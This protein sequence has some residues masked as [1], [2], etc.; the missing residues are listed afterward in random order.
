MK[1]HESLNALRM[2]S[3]GCTIVSVILHHQDLAI[4]A[5][6]RNG[7]A[8]SG[9]DVEFTAAMVETVFKYHTC[10][11]CQIAKWNHPAV[12][13]GSGVDVNQPGHTVYLDVV[14]GVQPPSNY[15]NTGFYFAV[16]NNTGKQFFKAIHSVHQYEAFLR[17]M[18]AYFW[19]HG[20][21]MVNLEA[22]L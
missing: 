3:S 18:H 12:G 4:A 2:R 22:H 8:W 9:I 13:V 16:C 17:S 20:H 5:A 15:G 10:I 1:C 11:A 14:M 21:R 19:K 6:L 7:E